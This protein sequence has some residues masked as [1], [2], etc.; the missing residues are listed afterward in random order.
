MK[1]NVIIRFL[2]TANTLGSQ[3]DVID[4]LE[5]VLDAYQFDYYGVIRQ[6]QLND[7]PLSLLLAGRWP[8]GWPARYMQRR[9]VLIDPTMR[10]LGHAQRGFRWADAIPAFRRD[11]NRRRMRRMIIDAYKFGLQAGYVF[12]VHGR[13]GLLGV[14]VAGGRPVTLTALE[15]VQFDALAKVALWRLLEFTDPLTSEALSSAVDVQ[16]TRREMEALGFLADGMTS[17][18]IAAVLDIS[19]HTVDWYMNAVQVKLKAKNR[20]H[21]V[22]IAFRHGLIS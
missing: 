9:Y 15:M 21:A 7:D 11:P 12:P 14:L 6:P 16:L 3:V 2:E 1:I 8:D 13:R 22:A 4:E 17:N 5:R 20:H 18:E 10:F 19:N